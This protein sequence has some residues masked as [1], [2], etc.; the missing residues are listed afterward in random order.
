[1]LQS[2]IRVDTPAAPWR[3][4]SGARRPPTALQWRTG[5]MKDIKFPGKKHRGSIKSEFYNILSLVARE[6]LAQIQSGKQ[7]D[8]CLCWLVSGQSSMFDWVA[9]I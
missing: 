9:Q 1:M 3:W 5:A 7:M 8:G 2:S 6:F 4:R